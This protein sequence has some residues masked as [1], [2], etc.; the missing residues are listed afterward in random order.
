MI[1]GSWIIIPVLWGLPGAGGKDTAVQ[2]PSIKKRIA[3]S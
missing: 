2:L 3:G 1:K